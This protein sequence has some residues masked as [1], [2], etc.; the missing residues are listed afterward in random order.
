[1]QIDNIINYIK[2][3]VSYSNKEMRKYII[4][5]SLS[6]IMITTIIGIVV[7]GYYLIAS[8]I[9][10]VFS[11][12]SIIAIFLLTKKTLPRTIKKRILM[13]L[14]LST[15]CFIGVS[16]LAFFVWT[17]IFEVN[18]FILLIILPPVITYVFAFFIT[19]N[20]LKA[21]N[22]KIKKTTV[23]TTGSAMCGT[24]GVLGMIISKHFLRNNNFVGIIVLLA[25]LV[26]FQCILSIGFN[27]IIK[28]FYMKKLEKQDIVIN[29][30]I[31]EYTVFV[32]GK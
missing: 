8:V 31:D 26:L 6:F 29:E 27:N 30:T 2:K 19:I 9:F 5:F 22:T 25:I 7:K 20:K 13:N 11:I 12:L 1:M 10:D 21:Q 32:N 16:L 23:I 4:V 18:I 15:Y 14:I 3:G 24:A 17:L 28:L